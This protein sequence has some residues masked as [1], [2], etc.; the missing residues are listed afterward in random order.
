MLPTSTSPIP[1]EKQ[2]KVKKEGSPTLLNPLKKEKRQPR[3]TVPFFPFETANYVDASVYS[4]CEGLE[5]DS[6]GWEAR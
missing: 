5:K 2:V 4:F 3:T 6:Y 1:S